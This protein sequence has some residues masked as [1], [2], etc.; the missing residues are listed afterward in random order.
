MPTRKLNAAVLEHAGVALDHLALQLEGAAHGVHHAAELDDRAVSGALDD[1][2]VMG[3][4]CW[5]DEVAAQAPQ[6]RER[7]LLVHAC[8]PAISDDIR[9]QDRRKLPG[10]AQCPSGRRKRGTNLTARSG[11]SRGQKRSTLIELSP[12]ERP[13]LGAILPWLRGE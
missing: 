2:A 1:A 11:Y 5:V 9:N 10:F 8:E 4:Y 12:Q 6:A 3:G 13:L 7:T